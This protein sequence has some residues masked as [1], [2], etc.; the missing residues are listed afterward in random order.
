MTARL[1]LPLLFAGIPGS[2]FRSV[3]CPLCL[4]DL[5]TQVGKLAQGTEA[6]LA[7]DDLGLESG[8]RIALLANVRPLSPTTSGAGSDWRTFAQLIRCVC[9]VV[10]VV[11]VL[12]VVLNEVVGL[13]AAADDSGSW[14]SEFGYALL[15]DHPSSKGVPRYRVCQTGVD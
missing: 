12:L 4:L 6:R 10:F 15:M 1:R 9:P 13:T 3:S 7:G 11:I 2:F 8:V 5:K 14:V